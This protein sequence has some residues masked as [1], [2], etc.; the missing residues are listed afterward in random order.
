[1]GNRLILKFGFLFFLIIL[2]GL[3]SQRLGLNT[4]QTTS[5]CIFFASV[6]TTLLFWDF[7]VAIAFLGVAI[8]LITH[9]VDLENLMRFAS[10]EVILFLVG[11]MVLVGL[12]KEAGF[13]PG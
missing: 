13:L 9:T 6:F 3:V 10:L 4:Q 1:M 12:L 11:M 5:L 2:V 7:R 8:L